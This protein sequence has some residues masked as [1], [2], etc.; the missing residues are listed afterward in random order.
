MNTL[1]G[2]D[3]EGKYELTRIE[4]AEGNEA[5]LFQCKAKVN[6][7]TRARLTAA[8]FASLLRLLPR[9]LGR[10]DLQVLALVFAF[11]IFRVRI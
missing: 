6:S 2:S 5:P 9:L 10:L 8:L 1:R 3:Q 4:T 7:P 11:L